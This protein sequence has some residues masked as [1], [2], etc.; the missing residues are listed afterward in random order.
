M[1]PKKNSANTKGVHRRTLPREFLTNA[2]TGDLAFGFQ[3]LG[4]TK[5]QLRDSAGITPDFAGIAVL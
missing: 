1:W 3:K 5:L 4:L 2:V